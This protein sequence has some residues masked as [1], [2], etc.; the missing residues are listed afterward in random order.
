MVKIEEGL[1]AYCR[2]DVSDGAAVPG[3]ARPN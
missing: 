3:L 1:E 2:R